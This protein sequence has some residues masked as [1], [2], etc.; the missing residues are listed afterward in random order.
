M[1][2]SSAWK[3]GGAVLG[4]IVIGVPLAFFGI[5]KVSDMRAKYAERAS[6]ELA[7]KAKQMIMATKTYHDAAKLAFETARRD[8]TSV[9]D[10]QW[11][12]RNEGIINF[13][14][15]KVFQSDEDHYAVFTYPTTYMPAGADSELNLASTRFRANVVTGEVAA[16]ADDADDW[17]VIQ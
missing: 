11:K 14:L 17:H 12:L 1:S 7:E 8:G 6:D 4:A 15:V 3:V 2:D 16:R 5:E 10:A 9:E 13:Q